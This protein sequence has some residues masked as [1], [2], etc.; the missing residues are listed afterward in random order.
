ME[1]GFGTDFS[2]VRLHTD[3]QAAQLS[4]NINAKAFTYGNDIY[5]NKGQYNPTADSGQHLIAHELTH[6]VQQNG[7]VGREENKKEQQPKNDNNKF[8]QKVAKMLSDYLTIPKM[9]KYVKELQ[10]WDAKNYADRK[11]VALKIL[12]DKELKGLKQEI[13]NII[14]ESSDIAVLSS[15]IAGLTLIVAKDI[16]VKGS[17][18]Q[19]IGA[20]F[21]GGVSF[22]LE[23]IK[24]LKINN[25]SGFVSYNTEYLNFI[26]R[27][28]LKANKDIFYGFGFG[29]ELKYKYM[30]L[31]LDTN[32]LFNHELKKINCEVGI[33]VDFTILNNI[34]L[35]NKLIWLQENDTFK[36]SISFNYRNDNKRINIEGSFKHQKTA[37]EDAENLHQYLKEG[38]AINFPLIKD[39]KNNTCFQLMFNFTYFF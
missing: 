31:K 15:M 19:K 32:Y 4:Q 12:S 26:L 37:S 25:L 10:N 8:A 21:S 5:F 35:K 39:E 14:G 16:P 34:Q 1:S 29:G 38:N 30:K 23:S 22:D 2:N 9:E 27:G 3:S 18:S 24:D 7:K 11:Q 6:V 13:V 28:I 36:G 33:G 20:G 17:W